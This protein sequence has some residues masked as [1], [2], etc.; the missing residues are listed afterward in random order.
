MSDRMLNYVSKLSLPS[1]S[2]VNFN[3]VNLSF[4]CR[5]KILEK[6]LCLH[7]E[8]LGFCVSKSV[9]QHMFDSRAVRVMLG[10]SATVLYDRSILKKS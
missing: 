10:I 3:E 2:L 4:D 9:V 7:G 6:V 8:I 5:S 1:Y